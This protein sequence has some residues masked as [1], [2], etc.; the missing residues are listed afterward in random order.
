MVGLVAHEWIEEHGGS[1]TVVDEILNT[2]PDA[3]LLCLWNDSKARYGERCVSETSLGRS[4]LR[5]KK[6]AAMPFMPIQWWAT[7][8]SKYDW[9]IASSHLF[10][11]HIGRNSQ[12]ASVPVFAYVHSPARYLWETEI[13]KRGNAV[14][15]KLAAMVL[16]RIDARRARGRI[17]YAANS[18]FV[19]ERIYRHWDRS[20]IVINPPVDIARIRRLAYDETILS[21]EER[22]LLA[23]IPDR[24][25]LGASR[26]V[27]YKQIEKVIEFGIATATA[28]VIAGD[29]PER[30]R[31]EEYAKQG[32][33]KTIFVGRVSDAVLYRLYGRAMVYVFPPIEDF[34]I[35]PVEAMAL[36]TPVVGNSVGGVAETIRKT[37]GGIPYD[38]TDY[39][40][41]GSVM[42]RA[43]A[44]DMEYASS[45]A[46]NYS[47]ERFQKEVLGW[48]RDSQLNQTPIQRNK[49]RRGP[50]RNSSRLRSKL[51]GE[52]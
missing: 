21:D 18:E 9:V 13:D 51:E 32:D 34:G 48:I 16:K 24:Y 30:K 2:F 42:E 26:L 45:Q 29:G 41:A 6:I 33:V 3:E 22:K 50:K 47:T 31:L 7:D 52:G 49:F 37:K 8:I 20:A 15:T 27:S 28:V 38:F 36:G 44:L 19:A 4:L 23:T 12:R 46:E 40:E 10:A 35:M 25:I 14:H 5:G 17:T 39:S 1:E 11:H 43:L